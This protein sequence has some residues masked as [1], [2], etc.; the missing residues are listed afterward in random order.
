MKLACFL[1]YTTSSFWVNDAKELFSVEVFLTHK[2]Q[3][4]F[5]A[6]VIWNAQ[7]TSKIPFSNAASHVEFYQP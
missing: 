7:L 5:H 1:T 2:N 6:N 3:L 4:W